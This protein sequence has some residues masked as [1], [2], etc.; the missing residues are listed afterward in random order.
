MDSIWEAPVRQ[1]LVARLSTLKPDTK[2]AWGR[3]NAAQMVAH[4]ADPMRGAMGEMEVADKKT[5]LRNPVLKFLV[6]YWL[7]WPK[8]APT[9][10]EYIHNGKEDLA[11]NLVMFG[12]T[13]E[14]FAAYSAKSKIHPHPAFGELSPKDWGCLTF[15][16]I[17][18]HCRQFG[19]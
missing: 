1:R 7:P 16:H 14:R 19:V 17:D 10:P 6:I 11:R 4:L 3:M 13:L 12:E 8:G 18:H 5:P 2:A 9:A 15:R